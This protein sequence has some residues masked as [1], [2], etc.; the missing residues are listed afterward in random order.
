MGI[1]Q[2][3]SPALRVRQPARVEELTEL[4]GSRAPPK[5]PQRQRGLWSF[6]TWPFVIAPIVAAETFLAGNGHAIAAEDQDDRADHGKGQPDAAPDQDQAAAGAAHAADDSQGDQT[7]PTRAVGT[8]P[9]A[10][11]NGDLPH[12][13]HAKA[14][15]AHDAL[16]TASPAADGGGGGGGGGGDGG[17]SSDAGAGDTS[18]SDA[19]ALLASDGAGGGSSGDLAGIPFGVPTEIGHP[20]VIGVSTGGGLSIDVSMGGEPGLALAAPDLVSTL[21]GSVSDILAPAGLG[22]LSSSLDLKDI[23]GFDLHVNSSGEFIATDLSTALDLHPLSSITSTLSTVANTVSTLASPVADGL[24]VLD[25]ATP[26][27]LDHLFGGDNHSATGQLGDLSSII[28]S[29][30]GSLASDDATSTLTGSLAGSGTASFDKLVDAFLAPSSD[31][32]LGTALPVASTTSDAAPVS[33]V[34]EASAVT[35][36]HSIDFPAPVLPEGDVLFRGNSYTDY[37]V[38]LQTVGP[39]TVSNSIATT[40]TSVASSPDAA[41]LAHVDTPVTNSAASSSPAPTA[42]HQDTSLTHIAT[43]LDDLSLRGHTH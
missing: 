16:A 20:I 3:D 28:G 39:S 38:A 17:G 7:D 9:K 15:V 34:G 2:T 19:N 33:I 14:P 4:A 26:N 6:L 5:I 22:G 29:G 35:P 32:G 25:F 36:G 21:T 41:S 37:H 43:A 1:K 40:L 13:E 42:P 23:L 11:H 30:S 10:S 12:E 24:P 8:M 31:A 27:V 18:S